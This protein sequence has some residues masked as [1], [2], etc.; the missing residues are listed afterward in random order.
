MGKAKGKTV[1][2][3]TRP[4]GRLAR[5][6]SMW[7]LLARGSIYQ[8][9]AILAIMAVGECALFRWS[10]TQKIG[11]GWFQSVRF[12]TVFSGNSRYVFRNVYFIL[13]I[14]AFCLIFIVL[15]RCETEN[16]KSRVSYTLNRLRISRRH[17]YL[18]RTLYNFLC[19]CLLFAVQIW[20]VLWMCRLYRESMPGVVG[21]QFEFLIFYRI[22][23]LHNLLPLAETAKWVRNLL[24]LLALSA[25]LAVSLERQNFVPNLSILVLSAEGYMADIGFQW[26]DLVID[27]VFAIVLLV[28]ALRIFGIWNGNADIREPGEE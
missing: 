20:T 16:S 15:L 28:A 22:P 26:I 13:F 10:L 24:V 1:P 7:A 25:D 2:E 5:E 12:E 21:S 27:I 6:L 18:V 9:L 17:L 3:R 11:R 8:I 14:A 23:F 4:S 19:F